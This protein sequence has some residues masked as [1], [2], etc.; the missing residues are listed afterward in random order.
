MENGDLKGS[1]I[2][3]LAEAFVKDE[4]ETKDEGKV[5]Y[6]KSTGTLYASNEYR[7]YALCLVDDDGF[8][9]GSIYT[10][11][12]P[13][14]SLRIC[15]VITPLYTGERCTFPSSMKFLPNEMRSGES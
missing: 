8:T 1:L 7:N 12:S 9:K 5:R 4:G 3:D 2:H 15:G 11:I 13:Y 10:A 6:N 14:A